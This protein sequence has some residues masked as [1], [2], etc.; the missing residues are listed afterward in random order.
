MTK[1]KIEGMER[2]ILTF[3]LVSFAFIFMSFLLEL[4]SG[5]CI[6]LLDEFDIYIVAFSL[7]VS[8]SRLSIELEDL[9]TKK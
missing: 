5:G 2:A 7:L 3:F 8:L 9:R 4:I 1:Y 6:S